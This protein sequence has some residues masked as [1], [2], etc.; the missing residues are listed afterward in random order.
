MTGRPRTGTVYFR[1]DQGLWH[2]AISVGGGKRR[3]FY[4][5]TEAEVRQKMADI[6]APLVKPSVRTP[7]DAHRRVV[8]QLLYAAVKRGR[9]LG[10]DDEL[11]VAIMAA[12]LTPA[13]IRYRI[14]G[15]CV[16]CG[17]EFAD[18]VDHSTPFARGG[19]DVP[20]NR[21]SACRQC[22]LRKGNLT[23]EEFVFAR[24]AVKTAVVTDPDE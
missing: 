24:S 11:L 15:P 2:G 7:I 17:S 18:T 4:A 20:E 6:G 16:Y 19:L 12:A 22:N 5:K 23:A 10:W 3:S 13:R 21:V 8:G 9:A 1:P 14:S